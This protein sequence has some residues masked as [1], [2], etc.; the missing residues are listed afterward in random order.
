MQPTSPNNTKTGSDILLDAH[1]SERGSLFVAEAGKQVP[2]VIK[3]FFIITDVPQGV[4]RG[5]HAHKK[6][7]QAVFCLRGSF[8]LLCDDG[9]SVSESK[10]SA[11]S[12]GVLLSSRVWHV[13]KDFSPD[14]LLL[15][16]ASE[17]Y[18]EAD[19][20]RDYQAFKDYVARN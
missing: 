8:A 19:Y 15:I 20:L 6:T 1:T 18:D 16:V 17:H 4:S 14:A 9:V 5:A 2:F 13:M 11:L 12:R 7:E 3:R 10:L